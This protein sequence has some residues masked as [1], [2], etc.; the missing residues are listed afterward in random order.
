D[1]ASIVDVRQAIKDFGE[2]YLAHVFTPGELS[3]CGQLSDPVPLLTAIFAAKEA[4]LKALAVDGAKPPWT[5]IEA[6]QHPCGRWRLSLSGPA[7]AVAARRG[8]DDFAL[9]I[10]CDGDLATATVI[11]T[12]APSFR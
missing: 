10:S 9:S 8:I 6:S 2:R 11:A 5:S 4:A 7:A 1:L 12:R 3:R